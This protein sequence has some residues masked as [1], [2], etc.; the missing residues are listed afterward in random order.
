M[1]KFI[2]M[3]IVFVLAITQIQAKIV[4]IPYEGLMIA[5]KVQD[6]AGQPKA[7]AGADITT[8]VGET[9]TIKGSGT[10]S[11]GTIVSYE[12]KKGNT[13]LASSASFN[14]T[15]ITEGKETLTLTV[16]D[17][18]GRKD[19]DTM[20]VTAVLNM[21]PVADAGGDKTVQVFETV[22]IT[23]TGSDS[24]G[25]IT[26]YQWL[27]NNTL[28]ATTA[29]F[30][31]TPTAVGTDTLIFVV[32]DNDGATASDSMKVTVT[33]IPNKPP[34]ANAGSDKSIQVHTPVTITGTASDPDG[35]IAS[36]KWTKNGKTIS[37]SLQFR[38]TPI[39]VGTDTLTLTVTD[40]DGAAAS[41]SMKVTVTAIPNKPPVANAQSVVTDEDIQKSI[42]LTGSDP[43][44]DTIH[45]IITQQPKH[46]TLTGSAPN[47]TYSPAQDYNGN[48]SFKFKVND[49]KDD[50]VE[51]VISIT[52]KPV[53]DAPVA[54]P[55]T[56]MAKQYQ[57]INIALTG[58]DVDVD[59]LTYRITQ[60]PS[61]GTL[62][63]TVPDVTY[64]PSATYIG[65]DSF[66]FVVNDGTLDSNEATVNI[67]I[68]RQKA[69]L[70][71]INTNN[72][73][74][75][76]K[77]NFIIPIFGGGYKYNV[78]CNNDGTFE[79]E[80]ETVS[81]SCTYPQPGTY[82]IAITG[83]FPQIYFN[84]EL[85][86]EKLVGILNWGNQK[87]RSFHNAF[88]GCSYMDMTAKD[89]PDLSN[90][91]DLSGMFLEANQYRIDDS[92]TEWDTSKI[93]NM[94][95]MF[96]AFDGGSFNKDISSW[97]TSSVTNMKA[98]F[99][100]RMYGPYDTT[101]DFNQDIGNWDTSN[102]TDMSEMFSNCDFNQDIGNW[103][104][105]N[106]TDMSEMFNHSQGPHARW[107]DFNQD[108]GNWDTSSVTNMRKMFY[109]SAFNQDI[110]NWDTSA[111]TDMGSMFS[112]IIRFNQDI[113]NWDTSSVTSMRGMFLA[114]DFN[115]DIGR[116]DTSSVTYMDGMFGYAF[117]QDIGSWDTSNVTSMSSMFSNS[118]FNQNIGNWDTSNVTSMSSM[119]GD[120][121]N[122]DIGSWDTSNVTDMGG[123]FTSSN[124]NQDIGNWDTSN[125]TSMS[126]MFSYNSHFNQDIGNWDTSNVTGMSGMFSSSKFNQ[127]I[128]NWDTSNVTN[129][130]YM[131][132]SS[133]FNQNIGSWDTSAVTDMDRMFSSSKFNQ[134]IGNWDTSNV[135][136]MNYMFSS[137]MFNQNIGSWDT[138]AVTDMD[139]MFYDASNFKNQD[140]SS[141]DVNKVTD[142]TEFCTKWGTGNTPPGGWS[143][144]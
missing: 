8:K 107:G 34:V 108:I 3:W 132:S 126:S 50:S 19:S 17:N 33:A 90:V 115:Q 74:T 1:K 65:T 28:L 128:G 24:D 141:W 15:P 119:F 144:P 96:G 52:V 136:N 109:N 7:D 83:V 61:H 43:D 57:D 39:A 67:Q 56:V 16:T 51:A 42:T 89:I 22:K 73:G 20:V 37:T 121:F 68:A 62:S 29:S 71:K 40:N 110:G 35:I 18:D 13:V 31:Y 32:T 12:W 87:W 76:G 46:G 41:D 98:M 64:T 21:P 48:D 138:S 53:N 139:S 103:D 2:F 130:N 122:Q 79:K 11:D 85:D 112:Y 140:L 91:T 72:P 47:V 95:Y 69:F 100:N 81:R 86:S 114:T 45:F 23:G 60:Q 63:G 78:D 131:F 142:H 92:I 125:V 101:S 9:V 120:A 143:C 30:D 111:V 97:D 49:G 113:G 66:K 129:M 5:V 135:T 104:T 38:Y 59:G 106:V 134:D 88:K 54:N 26:S 118:K 117:N 94:S 58:S 82:T 55:Q 105:S 102:V 84:G 6:P 4:L 80:N 75:S 99:I 36:K 44:S 93:E 133:M 27:K 70:I 123:M 127:D 10:D 14:Y 124:F 77:Y 25:K 116:W 137:S